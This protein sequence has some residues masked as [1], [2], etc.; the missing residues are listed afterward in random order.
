MKTVWRGRVRMGISP[1]RS[2]PPARS[3]SEDGYRGR[4][5]EL[6][7]SKGL[8]V[9]DAV[10]ARDG[11]L[12]YTGILMPRSELEDDSHIVLKLQDGYNVGI[13]IESLEIERLVQTDA[14]G[15]MRPPSMGALPRSG[16]SAA[17][18]AAE[19]GGITLPRV[20][21]VSTGGTIASRVDYRT[22][23]VSPALS[24]EDLYRA[25][26]ELGE[27]AE[28]RTE[29]LFSI[30]SE[31]MSPKHWA[32]IAQSVER[33]IRAGAD[34]VVVTH[35]TDTMGYTAAA[36]SF[37]LRN[38]P[39]PVVLVGSQRSSDRPSSDAALNLKG[40]VLTAARAP[41][42]EV[43][44]LMH[45]SP[46]DDSLAVH[47]G[48]RARKM[49]TSRRDAFRSVNSPLLAEVRGG[50]VLPA[51]GIKFRPR[52]AGGALE[53]KPHFEEDVVLIKSF[54]GMP[55]DVFDPIIHRGFRGIVLEGTG[56]GHVPERVF[57]QVKR[58]VDSGITV[59]MASQCIHGRVNMNVY[60][61][62]RELLS[63][64][65]IPA[66]DMLPETALVKLMWVLGQTEDRERVRELFTADLAGELSER[67]EYEGVP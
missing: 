67:S 33:H 12:T 65:V 35:G 31:N 24:A 16:P 52:G 2:Q 20:S 64:G 27:L 61:T 58:A 7:K 15:G 1:E 9:G 47:R 45:A 40:A 21:I 54:P 10:V 30:L 18:Q 59:V 13:S 63:I 22:G 57:S 36:L 60:S 43:C 41:F 46:S 25:V 11:R 19:G 8:K 51:P 48:T 26:P 28:I 42:A 55:P 37:A 49:H 3:K 6:L 32:S 66:G 34:G 29:I 50:E 17:Q 38:L 53:V 44:V 39:V 4:V 14:A 5:L 56:L 23:A 62:G